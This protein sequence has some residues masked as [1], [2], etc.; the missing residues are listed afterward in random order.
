MAAIQYNDK[1]SYEI[2][3]DGYD[4]YLNGETWISQR[5]PYDKVYKPD[6]TYEENALIQL[7]ELN[8]PPVELDENGNEIVDEA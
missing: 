1:H 8:A 5:K 2:F 7:E 6:G 4:I 3:E